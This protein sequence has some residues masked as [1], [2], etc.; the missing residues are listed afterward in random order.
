MAQHM[1]ENDGDISIALQPVAL[2]AAPR[3]GILKRGEDSISPILLKNP[4]TRLFKNPSSAGMI[5]IGLY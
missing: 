2:E 5:P 4:K 3:L 1:W